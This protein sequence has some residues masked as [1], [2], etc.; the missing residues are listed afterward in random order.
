MKK[1]MLSF[2][3]V[4][5]GSL[6]CQKGNKQPVIDGMKDLHTKTIISHKNQEYE[7]K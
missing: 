7:C 1:K 6:Q 5:C 2:R 4:L 3:N